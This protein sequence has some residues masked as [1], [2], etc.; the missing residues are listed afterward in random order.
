ME[1]DTYPDYKF[2]HITNSII[3]EGLKKHTYPYRY[4]FVDI[5]IYKHNKEHDL[6]TYR[7]ENVLKTLTNIRGFDANQKWPNETVLKPFGDFKM[8]VSID[9]HKYLVKAISPNW[10]MVGKTPAYDHYT[11]L[12]KESV[13][14][15][16]PL[17][18]YSPAKPFCLSTTRCARKIYDKQ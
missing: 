6:L 3:T 5:W 18:L 17:S 13:A 8:R 4:P 16:I 7:S 11:D 12:S 15:E 9:N 10:L 14:F 1:H 2:F